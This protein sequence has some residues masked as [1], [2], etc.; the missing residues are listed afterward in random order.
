MTTA[1]RELDPAAPAGPSH[2][3]AP[4]WDGRDLALGVLLGIGVGLAIQLLAS[5]VGEWP[6][7]QGR[8][9]GPDPYM[10]LNRVLECQGGSGCP[11][12]L[13]PRSNSPFGET[14]HWPFLQDWL[15]IGLAAPFRVFMDRRGAIE[16]AAYL[17]GPLLQLGAVTAVLLAARPLSRGRAWVLAGVFMSCQLWVVLAFAPSRPDHHGLQLLFFL[18]AMAAAIRLLARGPSDR[19]TMALGIALGGGLWVSV[20]GLATVTVPLLA[21]GLRWV[22]EGGRP[23]ARTNALAAFC[24]AGVLVLGLWLDGP[25]SGLWAVEYDRFSVVHVGVIAGMA[26]FWAVTLALASEKMAMARLVWC[27]GGA[28]SLAGVLAW[29]FPGFYGGPLVDVDPRII[30]IWLDQVAEYVPLPESGAGV[31]VLGIGSA[32][33]AVPTAAAA[34]WAGEEGERWAWGLVIGALAWFG[35]LGLVHGSRWSY[36]AQVLTPIPFAWL[37]GRVFEAGRGLGRPFLRAAANVGIVVVLALAVPVGVA[38]ARASKPGP[39]G[40]GLPGSLTDRAP[41]ACPHAEL[42]EFA[43]T[44]PPPGESGRAI[45]AT[46]WWG[47]EILYRTDLHVIATPYHRNADGILASFDIMRATDET[48]IAGR[49]EERGIGLIAL[50]MG[51]GWAP[52]LDPVPPGSLYERLR[53]GD[54]PRFI[55][56]LELPGAL[57]DRYRLWRVETGAGS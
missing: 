34:L 41:V 47:P 28:A 10:R 32:M 38:T 56:P 14:L 16:A 48:E 43:A 52:L 29:T 26:T 39:A 21:L 13:Y 19:A 57:A 5:L 4:G 30:P 9:H 51:E 12:G 17:L 22:W 6:I 20:E 15:L 24:C 2:T 36:Y 7:F 49:L 37:A 54:E 8:F 31:L 25:S 40:G 3:G 27:A 11:G 33:L 50:C 1:Q 45:L 53:Q 35:L 44:L 46:I 18:V 55:R 23:W 42:R